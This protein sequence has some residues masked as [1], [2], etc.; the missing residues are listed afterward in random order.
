[1]TEPR[2][3]AERA[4]PYDAAPRPGRFVWYDLMSTDP[5]A[6]REYYARLFGWT[7]AGMPMDGWTY[8]IVSAG[9]TQLGGIMPLDKSH[10]IPSH[11]VSYCTVA[12]VD[13]T[14]ARAEAIGGKT[15]VPPFDIP[16]GRMA[17]V[18]DPQGA[19]FSPLTLSSP[20]G[21]PPAVSPP[22]TFCWCELL[23]RDPEGAVPFYATL[24]GWTMETMDMGPSGT[25]W[26]F[27]RGDAFAGGML[28]MPDDAA[29]PRAMWL[30]Y[31]AVESADATAAR[32]R[33]LGGMIH[34]PPTDVPTVGRF[35]VTSDPQ[36][37]T[38]AMLEAAKG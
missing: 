31:V 5:A 34:V 33:E 37:A 15:C 11:W 13:E 25:Y 16:V 17:V 6:S 21:E 23:T 8:E 28:R 24:F 10:G 30:P 20:H 32:V 38:I 22:G 9:E 19:I 36:G 14:C 7:T 18:E 2:T 27:K 26:L 4:A 29:A 35:L 3:D 12:N 1:M